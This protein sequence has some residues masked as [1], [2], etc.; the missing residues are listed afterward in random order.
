M[1]TEV[2][3]PERSDWSSLQA[4]CVEV[5]LQVLD[6]IEVA[7]SGHYGSSLSVVEILVSIYYGL[8][9][10]RERARSARP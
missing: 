9:A 4:K 7:G 10:V 5:R 3:V 8:F 2:T 1:T 6:G